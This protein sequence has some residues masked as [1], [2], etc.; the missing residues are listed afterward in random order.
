MCLDLGLATH[1]HPVRAVDHKRHR[2][3]PIDL[4]S[5]PFAGRIIIS[6]YSRSLVAGVF[7][8]RTNH[9]TTPL[10]SAWYQGHNFRAGVLNCHHEP[11]KGCLLAGRSPCLMSF[12]LS[13]CH[14]Q[15]GGPGMTR[16]AVSD[17]A[18]PKIR[19]RR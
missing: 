4:P 1:Y 13:P 19:S 8:A 3:S 14:S 15:L 9:L 10:L 2:T 5:T 12:A 17:G 16:T 18:T 11:T 7:F 6:L